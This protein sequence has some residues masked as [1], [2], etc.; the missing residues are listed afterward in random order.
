MFYFPF[1]IWDVILPIDDSIIFQD[2]RYTTNQYSD[3][4]TGDSL[5]RTVNSDNYYLRSPLELTYL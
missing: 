3:L 2:G 1:H 5:Q 4:R